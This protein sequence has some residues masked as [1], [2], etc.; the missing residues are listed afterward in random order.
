MKKVQIKT[1]ETQVPWHIAESAKWE[2]NGITIGHATSI[3]DDFSTYSTSNKKDCIRFHFGIKGDYRFTFKQISKSYDLIGGH[4]N[5]L[6]SNGL[7]LEIQNKS[8]TIVTFG[9][10]IPKSMFLDM[11]IGESKMHRN[12][13]KNISKDRSSIY[14]NR[15]GT[16]TIPIQKI[17]DEIILNPYHGIL[18]NAFLLAKTLEL[19]VLCLDQYQKTTI[20]SD[21]VLKNKHDKEKVIAARD[22]LNDRI[23]NP[24]ILSEIAREVGLNEFKLKYGFK[25]IFNNTPFGYL[26]E[27]RLNLAKQ[28]LK[29]T[30]KTTS[31]I[32]H[33]LGYSSPQHFHYKFKKAFGVTPN[34][35][36][37]N[38]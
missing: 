17:I 30:Q 21:T 11:G 3:F 19:L 31:E 12:F 32:A 5:L 15:W 18:Q 6:Y 35:V 33:E 27:R 10:E 8:T 28:Y 4:H 9:I 7:D 29:D 26:T 34:Y 36:R 24:P 37:N 23:S 2:V 20:N 22:F 14:S 25:E 38:P 1:G 13:V 16:M